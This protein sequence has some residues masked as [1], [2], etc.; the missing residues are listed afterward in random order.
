MKKRLKILI[1]FIIVF[2][3]V[4]TFVL[5]GEGEA[6]PETTIKAISRNIINAVAWFAYAIA[7][8]AL[9]FI[10]IKYVMSGANE[11]ANIK[12]MIPKYLIGI[13]LIVCCTAIVQF[14]VNVAGNDTAEE[15][16]GVGENI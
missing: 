1:C 7:L 14:F 4:T 12:G 10:G 6:G 5:A 16:I 8:G 15:I 13:A 9:I 2:A 3:F 11:R